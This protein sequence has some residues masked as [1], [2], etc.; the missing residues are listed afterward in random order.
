MNVSKRQQVVRRHARIRAKVKGTLERPRL[1]VFRSNRY[2]Y[3]QIINDVTSKTLCASSS[4]ELELPLKEAAVKVGA[5][6]AQKAKKAGIT[7]VVFDRG[8]FLFTGKIKALAESARS[9][10]LEF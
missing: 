1:A 8:G 2:L 9:A 6:I 10:G 4:L 7:K 5:D 3:A